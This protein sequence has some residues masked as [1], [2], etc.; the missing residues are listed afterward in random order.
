M[1]KK[2]FDSFSVCL[3]QHLALIFSNSLVLILLQEESTSSRRHL[4]KTNRENCRGK[5]KYTMQNMTHRRVNRETAF[6]PVVL[7]SEKSQRK[8]KKIKA[9][10]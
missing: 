2:L 5:G 10:L 3:S 6:F 4:D 1:F 8:Q 7:V 9:L